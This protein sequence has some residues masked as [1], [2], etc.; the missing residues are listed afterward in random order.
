MTIDLDEME[1][2][3]GT[4]EPT[5]EELLKLC[6]EWLED[7]CIKA[8]VALECDG[9]PALADAL[10][11]GRIL[12]R[13]LRSRLTPLGTEDLPPLEWLL[14]TIEHCTT[15][16]F[17]AQMF[18]SAYNSHIRTLTAQPTQPTWNAAEFESRL[19]DIL[20]YA[21]RNCSKFENQ[22]AMIAKDLLHYYPQIRGPWALP[23]R[24]KQ[25]DG[26]RPIETAR[27]DLERVLGS[28]GKL[29]S[30]MYARPYH[31]L[32]GG[33]KLEWRCEKR[34][35]GDEY[36]WVGHEIWEPTHW[37]PLPKP[38]TVLGEGK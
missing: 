27:D 26:W 29:V 4:T 13:A 3:A 11:E 15:G 20:D 22:V 2:R 35:T 33:I 6:D 25:G 36:G 38:P 5:P 8:A 12:A 28:D 34:V 16:H 1:K 23:T 19:H 18:S 21:D 10:R 24:E 7:G 31:A 32:G 9:K 30:A 17:D 14:D 37:R